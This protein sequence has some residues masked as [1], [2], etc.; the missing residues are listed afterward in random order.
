MLSHTRLKQYLCDICSKE[1]T[2]RA[3][4]IKH[5]KTHHHH[6]NENNN[7]GGAADLA[8]QNQN[9]GDIIVADSSLDKI[10]VFLGQRRGGGIG[11]FDLNNRFASVGEGKIQNGGSAG[12]FIVSSLTTNL[13]AASPERR[14]SL[15]SGKSAASSPSTT[16]TSTPLDVVTNKRANLMDTINRLNM[17]SAAKAEKSSSGPTS[18]AAVKPAPPGGRLM[19]QPQPISAQQL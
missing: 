8:D 6:N 14:L 4:F 7:T 12:G 3:E 18:A 5:K 1:F 19:N 9:K 16:T 15:G 10:A 17:L 11:G 2:V 13:A